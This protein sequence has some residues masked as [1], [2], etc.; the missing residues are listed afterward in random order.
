MTKKERKSLI[1]AEV[2]DTIKSHGNSMYVTDICLYY[3]NVFKLSKK[4]VINCIFS[5]SDR[6]I[7]TTEATGTLVKTVE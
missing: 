5:N 7:I 2:I 3:C 6:F 1:L 4:I